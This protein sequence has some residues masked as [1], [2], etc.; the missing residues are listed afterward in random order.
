MP[1]YCCLGNA[2]SEIEGDSLKVDVRFYKQGLVETLL[3]RDFLTSLENDLTLQ[4]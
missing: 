3:S 1:D 2:N 4:P